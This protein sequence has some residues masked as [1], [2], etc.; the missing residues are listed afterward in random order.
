MAEKLDTFMKEV[1]EDLRREQLKKLW[2][3]YGLLAIGGVVAILGAVWL[4]T[5]WQGRRQAAAE[6]LNA[7][8][9]AASRLVRDGKSDAAM[10]A[11]STIAKAGTPAYQALA[12]LRIAAAHVKSGRLAEAVAVYD[13]IAANSAIDQILRE[14]AGVQAAS[15]RLDTADFT[16]MERRLTPLALDKAPWRSTA[17]ELMGLAAYKAG[18][19]AEARKIFED[20]LVD[21]G[22]PR[23]MGERAQLMLAVLTDAEAAKP[24]AAPAAP[25]AEPE[26][27]KDKSA[28]P[29]P[30]AKK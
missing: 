25:K 1:D 18:K 30:A 9:E 5:Y 4:S 21:R 8:L 2:D 15:L 14:F 17:R 23:A 16:E 22:V 26:K 24:A 7:Q 6:S 28:A 19:L 27:S 10:A 20:L 13:Q 3:Q 11:F 12:G 29:P